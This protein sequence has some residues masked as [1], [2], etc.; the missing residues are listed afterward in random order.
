MGK[1]RGHGEGSLYQRNDGRWA[2][3]VTV[4][5]TS[6]GKQKRKTVYGK[7]QAEALAKL[8]E[9]K[10]QITSGA[11]N[12]KRLKVSDYLAQWLEHKSRSIK[13][14][15]KSK[16][17]YCVG[18]IKRHIGGL[19]LAK[20]KPLHVQAMVS[21][22]ADDAGVPTANN[23]R[24]VL[25][26]AFRQA[27]RWQVAVRNPA[28]AVDPLKEERR[29]MTLWTAEQAA[30]FLDCARSHRLYAL[31]YV[32]MATGMRRGE[33]LGLRWSDIDGNTISVRQTLVRAGKELVVSTPKTKTGERRIAV[34]SDL[35]SV[36][37]AQETLQEAERAQALDAWT[38]S[39]L[40]FTNE[41][42]EHLQPHAIT[43]GLT[44]LAKKAEIPTLRFHDLRHLHAS[45]CI[46]NGMDPK[47]LADRL[48]HARASFTL[49]T[50]THLF[51]NGQTSSPLGLT[52]LLGTADH[53]QPN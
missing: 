20:V 37:A 44:T 18:H 50:Y 7:T 29:D 46:R 10:R 33:I 14:S 40:V 8:D 31:F 1:R 21:A 30:K 24:R 47:S 19:Q 5:F 4:G 27:V 17:E 16:Y 25:F 52:K 41:I 22:V 23:C 38:D 34:A 28:E 12:D 3:V 26:N 42:G 43:R 48:G 6:E 53:Q 36:L 45:M 51:Q 49:D 2:G 13:P 11:F 32:A 15:T 9:V 39:G 35:L